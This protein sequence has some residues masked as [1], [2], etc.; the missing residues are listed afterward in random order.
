MIGNLLRTKISIPI[1]DC[2]QNAT[3]EY[4]NENQLFLI[5]DIIADKH[6]Y[7]DWYVV[8]YKFGKILISCYGDYFDL[9]Y[10]IVKTKE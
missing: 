4:L 5:T 10:E 3:I 6:Y 8:Y 1:Y 9:Y 7:Y 2:S